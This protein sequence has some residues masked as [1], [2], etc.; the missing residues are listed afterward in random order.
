M[1][2]DKRTVT[3]DALETLGM[4]I[5]ENEKRDAIH[6][7]VENVTAQV[8]LYPGQ[9]VGPDGTT[10]NPVGIVDPFL[11]APVQP[12]KR[13]WLVIYP[14]Q[15]KSLRHVW[16][17][18]AFPDEPAVA[19]ALVVTQS[20]KEASLQW[21]KEYANGLGVHFSALLDGADTWVES[22]KDSQWGE[23]FCQGG[24]LEGV[25]TDPKFWTHYEIV[26]GVTVPNDHKESFFTCSC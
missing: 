23:Y 5:S 3:T 21:I 15:I 4:L 26:R 20:P 13:F 22:R 12:G 6:L 7:A 19:T 1:S 11:K 16:S 10:L 18:P 2:A 17:H 14:R 8:K 9:D 25:G 24:I